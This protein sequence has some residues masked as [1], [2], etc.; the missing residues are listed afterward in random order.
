MRITPILGLSVALTLL[1]VSGCRHQTGVD[2]DI[3]TDVRCATTPMS[4]GVELGEFMGAE[5]RGESPQVVTRVCTEGADGQP[6]RVGD[7]V[8]AASAGNDN[9]TFRLTVMA[10]LRLSETKE[11]ISPE[12]CEAQGYVDCI[13]A[14]RTLG[15]MPNEGLTLPIFL[16]NACASRV[17]EDGKTCVADAK[18]N[19]RCVS[20]QIAVP[21][22]CGSKPGGCVFPELSAK[23]DDPAAEQA[24]KGSSGS[25]GSGGSGGGSGSGG[26][27]PSVP[28]IYANTLDS[29]VSF[30][31]VKFGFGAPVVFKGCG[32]D[33]QGNDIAVTASGTMYAITNNRLYVVDPDGTCHPR[34]VAMSGLPGVGYPYTL[35]IMP[36]GIIPNTTDDVLVGQNDDAYMSIGQAQGVLA[37]INH[38]TKCPS[39]SGDVV[40]VQTASGVKA[41]LAAQSNVG[42]NDYLVEI[43]TKNGERVSGSSTR[44]FGIR[45]VLGLAYWDGFFYGFAYDGTVIKMNDKTGATQKKKFA[46]HFYG[47]ASPANAPTSL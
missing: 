15:F 13:V 9:A 47:A 32:D 2:V 3:T 5:I 39:A 10:N 29:F 40:V 27:M 18:L 33:N 11:A 16:Q 24:T 22:G 17:C 31:P 28:S 35:A 30:D 7:I 25:G 44:S 12:M 19:V 45:G 41:Y 38:S 21:A 42:L 20:A 43:D 37:L 46:F 34:G 23:P 26:G 14:R 1:L 36:S 6:N 4:T 8:V